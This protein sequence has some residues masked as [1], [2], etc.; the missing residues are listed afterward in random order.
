MKIIFLILV[1]FVSGCTNQNKRLFDITNKECPKIC[2]ERGW[3]G[4]LLPRPEELQCVCDSAI[5][6]YC[7]FS[8][9]PEGK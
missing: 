6:N 7:N 2:G 8:Y 9:E 3:S 5:T 1:L 4:L